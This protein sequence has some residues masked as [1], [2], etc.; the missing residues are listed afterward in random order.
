MGKISYLPLVAQNQH[1]YEMF[2][3]RLFR[4]TA[5]PKIL[6][7]SLQLNLEA[8]GNLQLVRILGMPIILN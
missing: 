3:F 7:I 1:K 5:M 2:I 6:N 4:I 8:Q